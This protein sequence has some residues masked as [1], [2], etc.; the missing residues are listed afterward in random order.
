M[1]VAPEVRGL[2]VG[3]ALLAALEA[4]ARRLGLA[5]VCLETGV[6]Q[7]RAL[8]LYEHNGFA[9]IAP[10]GEYVGSSLSLCMAKDL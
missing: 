10:F 5:R 1:Y 2:G 6:R 3:Q 9:R 4:E 8:A 7:G